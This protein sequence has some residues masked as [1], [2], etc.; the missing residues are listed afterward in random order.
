[1][2]VLSLFFIDGMTPSTGRERETPSRVDFSELH[3][4][5]TEKK[6]GE[7]T[8]TSTTTHTSRAQHKDTHTHTFTHRMSDG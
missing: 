7:N 2:R 3:Y 6:S 4:K 8:K 1:M 5:N